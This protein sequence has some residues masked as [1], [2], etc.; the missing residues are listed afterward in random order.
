M[1]ELGRKGDTSN[2]SPSPLTHLDRVPR[3]PG[4]RALELGELL[5]QVVLRGRHPRPSVGRED[6]GG[7]VA[8]GGIETRPARS[9]GQARRVRLLISPTGLGP[10]IQAKIVSDFRAYMDKVTSYA[11]KDMYSESRSCRTAHKTRPLPAVPCSVLLRD[12]DEIPRRGL[13]VPADDEIRAL[14]ALL[15]LEEH[16]SVDRDRP[17]VREQVRSVPASRL[18]FCRRVLTTLRLLQQSCSAL[19]VP[20]LALPTSSPRTHAPVGRPRS[21]STPGRSRTGRGA[22]RVSSRL[23]RRTNGS[24]GGLTWASRRGE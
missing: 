3:W 1:G 13:V 6:V 11:W 9:G 15:L 17:A 14:D 5:Q 21:V 4:L 20:S 2:P 23:S 24:F 19:R 7:E 22:G 8:G 16:Q 10:N 12:E 18:T